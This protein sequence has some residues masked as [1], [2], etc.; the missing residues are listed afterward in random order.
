MYSLT[1]WAP[2]PDSGGL[3]DAETLAKHSPVTGAFG[4][5]LADS[6]YRVMIA[7]VKKT[8]KKWA[9][10]PKQSARPKVSKQMMDIVVL[11]VD[12]KIVVCNLFL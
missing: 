3:Q 2:T 9:F 6:E 12:F 10:T 8:A 7:G 5:E 1:G 4:E 11:L